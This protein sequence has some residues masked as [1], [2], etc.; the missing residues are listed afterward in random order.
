MQSNDGHRTHELDGD[1]AQLHDMRMIAPFYSSFANNGQFAEPA[2]MTTME[3]ARAR[4]VQRSATHGLLPSYPPAC[5]RLL[6]QQQRRAERLR[7]LQ[8]EAEAEAATVQA[9]R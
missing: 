7:A 2:Y 5:E 3:R 1:I 9:E 8:A 6:L 4:R